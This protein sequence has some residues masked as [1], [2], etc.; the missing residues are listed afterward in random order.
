M[1]PGGYL[2]GAPS[3]ANAGAPY[4]RVALVDEIGHGRP[5]RWGGWPRLGEARIMIGL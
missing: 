3:G 5:A 1:L 4:I 2:S